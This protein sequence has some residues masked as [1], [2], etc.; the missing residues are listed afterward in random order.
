MIIAHL[1]GQPEF[2]RSRVG[3]G[4]DDVDAVRFDADSIRIR[5]VKPKPGPCLTQINYGYDFGTIII[6]IFNPF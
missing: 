6:E 2:E 4:F 3:L 1:I 5:G